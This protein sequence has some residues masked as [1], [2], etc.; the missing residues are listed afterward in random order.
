[1]ARQART[2]ASASGM[3][4][5]VRDGGQTLIIRVDLGAEPLG[6]SKSGK[7]LMRATTH[8]PAALQIGDRTFKVGLNVWQE[9]TAE[10]QAAAEKAAAQARA[11]ALWGTPEA[12]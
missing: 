8:G 10:Q 3:A 1:M 12:E 7:S 11:T 9:P 5:E 4:H 2:L 6:F